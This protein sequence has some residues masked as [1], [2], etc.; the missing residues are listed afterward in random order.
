MRRFK[1]LWKW[2]YW[3]NTLINLSRFHFMHKKIFTYMTYTAFWKSIFGLS[4]FPYR[5]QPRSYE[6][7]YWLISWYNRKAFW[8]LYFN[9]FPERFETFIVQIFYAKIHSYYKHWVFLVL[10][11]F[12]IKVYGNINNLN[13]V[14]AKKWIHHNLHTIRL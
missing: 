7:I 14:Y 1:E 8:K 9:R 10:S 5:V 11:K 13:I 2:I 3:I 12:K 4:F 6:V